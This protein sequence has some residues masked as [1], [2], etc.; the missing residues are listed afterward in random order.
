ML[1]LISHRVKYRTPK[2]TKMEIFVSTVHD[3]QPLNA[4]TKNFA[5]EATG[6]LDPRD[7]LSITL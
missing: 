2:A 4:V 3:Y 6:M 5:L 7:R 1:I